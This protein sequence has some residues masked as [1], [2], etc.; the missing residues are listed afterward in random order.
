MVAVASLLLYDKGRDTR[1]VNKKRSELDTTVQCRSLH[2]VTSPNPYKRFLRHIQF[3]AHKRTNVLYA[4]VRGFSPQTFR[5]ASMPHVILSEF[6]VTCRITKNVTSADSRWKSGVSL[7]GT[8]RQESDTNR[9]RR[10]RRMRISSSSSSD[11]SNS[12]DD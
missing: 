7:G 3:H 2:R 11:T 5:P 4:R 12:E 8:F 1:V 10:G 6:L 9:R